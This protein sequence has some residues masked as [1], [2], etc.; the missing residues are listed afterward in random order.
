MRKLLLF[1]LAFSLMFNA[2]PLSISAMSPYEDAGNFLKEL[3]I[4]K[5]DANGDLKPLNNLTREES[6]AILLRMLNEES[7]VQK[8]DAKVEFKDVPMGHWAI[9]YV[10][11]AKSKDLTK[12]VSAD[13][14]GIKQNVTTKQFATFML[15]ALNHTAD[16][17]T[18]D[19]MKKAGDLGLLKGSSAKENDMI[20]RGDAFI[21]MKNTLNTQVNNTKMSL[22]DTLKKQGNMAQT[23]APKKEP[24][25]K[26][27]KPQTPATQD[28]K[29]KPDLGI[30]ASFANIEVILTEGSKEIRVDPNGTN[31]IID[32]TD[33]DKGKDVNI[34]GTSSFSLDKLAQQPAVKIYVPTTMWDD[35]SINLSSCVLKA[36]KVFKSADINLNTSFS[37]VDIELLDEFKGKIEVNASSGTINLVSQDKFKDGTFSINS[38]GTVNLPPKEKNPPP[39]RNFVQVILDI[40]YQTVVNVK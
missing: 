32:S 11:Y 16:W 35:V 9:K 19:I 2:L 3:S 10:S 39:N 38:S 23:P 14:F 27:E 29:D 1:L 33:V 20:L 17:A 4:I 13:L 37:N 34:V 31:Y 18:E 7:N 15:R 12:G 26:P 30:N 28:Q 36:N 21:I 6:L 24:T 40:S 22:L 25:T 5:G 8:F